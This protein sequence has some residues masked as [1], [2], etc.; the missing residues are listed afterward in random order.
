MFSLQVF[1]RVDNVSDRFQAYTNNRVF[2]SVGHLQVRGHFVTVHHIPIEMK[3]LIAWVSHVRLTYTSLHPVGELFDSFG[4][5]DDVSVLL[6]TLRH[7][8]LLRVLVLA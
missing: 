3:L 1:C 2:C 8:A 5:D 7:H 6:E 4:R